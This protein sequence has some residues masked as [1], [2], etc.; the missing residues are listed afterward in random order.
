MQSFYNKKHLSLDD[1]ENYRGFKIIKSCGHCEN[2]EKK[3]YT[4]STLQIGKSCAECGTVSSLIYLRFLDNVFKM[5]FPVLKYGK[6]ECEPCK[7]IW[8]T[9]FIFWGCKHQCKKCFKLYYPIDVSVEFFNLVDFKEYQK[10]VLD[11]IEKNHLSKFCEKCVVKGDSCYKMSVE[12]IQEIEKKLQIVKKKY[13]ET[14]IDSQEAKKKE[15]N[16]FANANDLSNKKVSIGLDLEKEKI[17]EN[18]VLLK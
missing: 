2:Q 15:I 16:E 1:W 12:E 3:S 8:T 4:F 17:I 6:F 5:H 11:N 14:L 10:P 7:N 18:R 13:I 9:F